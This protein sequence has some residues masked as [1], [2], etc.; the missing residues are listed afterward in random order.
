MAR[1]RHSRSGRRTWRFP[2]LHAAAALVILLGTCLVMYP[3]VASWFSQLE[4][5]RVTEV[6]RVTIDEPPNDDA[7]FRAA[8]MQEAREYNDA[9]ESGAIY[10][11]NS[12]V[13]TGEGVA[14]DGAFVYNDILDVTG[15]GFMGRLMYDSL[16]IDLPIFH[17][18][19]V[20]TLERGVGHLEG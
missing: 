18:T 19:S 3:H 15:T 7:S 11:A 9:L 16:D 2:A 4:Q 10:R 1:Q 13:A 8:R 12:N 20:E 17:G 14:A 6:A 5:S